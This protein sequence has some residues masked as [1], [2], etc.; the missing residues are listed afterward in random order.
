MT[1]QQRLILFKEM[2]SNLI[3]I[4]LAVRGYA[5]PKHI[6]KYHDKE[7][8]AVLLGLTSKKVQHIWDKI[9]VGSSNVIGLGTMTCIECILYGNDCKHCS[10]GKLHGDCR[11]DTESTYSFLKS[12]KVYHFITNEDYRDIIQAVNIAYMGSLR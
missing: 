4:I 7:D 5:Y 9:C 2:K 11:D 1:P 8:E 3:D 6:L 10:Y 12:C